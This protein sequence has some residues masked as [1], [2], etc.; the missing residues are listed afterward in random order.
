MT[1]RERYA[2]PVDVHLILRRDSGKGPEVLL[3][4]RAGEVYAAGLWH[5]PSGHLDG[6][7]EDMVDGV[8]RE[9]AEETG[10]TIDRA[11]VALAT[12]VH[13]RSPHG[14]ARVGVF[15]EVRDF[16]GEPGIMEPDLCDAMGWYPL[17]ALPEPMVAYCRAGLDAYRGGRPGAV[18]FQQPGDAVPHQ[19]DGPDRTR[20]LTGPSP[21]RGPSRTLRALLRLRITHRPGTG[22]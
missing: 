10:I 3:S 6:P 2:L 18:H 15:F 21:A 1:G 7:H 14:R 20:L 9:A 13:H 12:T 11:D 8:I 16:T 5:L 4:R 17:D 22:R 19:P